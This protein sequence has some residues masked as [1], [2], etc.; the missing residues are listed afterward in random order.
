[1]FRFFLIEER[2]PS[3]AFLLNPKVHTLFYLDTSNDITVMDVLEA[4][5][6]AKESISDYSHTTHIKLLLKLQ[7]NK[8]NS[9]TTSN[10][11]RINL[12]KHAGYIYAWAS[13]FGPSVLESSYDYYDLIGECKNFAFFGWWKQNQLEQLFSWLE[14]RN[15][16]RESYKSLSFGIGKDVFGYKRVSMNVVI[17]FKMTAMQLIYISGL[18]IERLDDSKMGTCFCSEKTVGFG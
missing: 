7:A 17:F 16:R 14:L 12:H 3:Y 2:V 15:K 4:E 5:L 9:T 6:R 11:T 10:K 8:K 13:L 1:M 18:F